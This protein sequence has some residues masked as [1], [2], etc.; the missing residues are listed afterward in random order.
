[1]RINIGSR[2]LIGEQFWSAENVVFVILLAYFFFGTYV[3]QLPGIYM[4]EI[5]KWIPIFRAVGAS[6][7]IGLNIYLIPNY[8]VIGSA[9]ATVVAFIAMSLSIF[10]RT[11]KIFPVAYNWIA[12]SYPI[13]FM[14]IVFFTGDDVFNRSIVTFCYPIGWYLFAINSE[15]KIIVKSFIQ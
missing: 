13:L 1:M 3:V 7:N 12:C 10:L 5:T 4:K 14:G 11:Y 9:W 15:E 2:P 6:V 8:G